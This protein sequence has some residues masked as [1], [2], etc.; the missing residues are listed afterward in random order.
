MFSHLQDWQQPSSTLPFWS[1]FLASSFFFTLSFSFF[2]KFWRRTPFKPTA[3]YCDKA[4]MTMTVMVINTPSKWLYLQRNLFFTPVSQNHLQASV[5]SARWKTDHH[6]TILFHHFHPYPLLP[7]NP[8]TC[9][10]TRLKIYYPPIL[11][12]YLG[13]VGGW[14]DLA[15]P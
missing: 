8:P 5:G 14:F 10:A 2:V 13:K 3:F 15:S 6:Q 1:I 12:T 9:G 7:I 11:P 4:L